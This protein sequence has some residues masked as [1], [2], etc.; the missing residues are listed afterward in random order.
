MEPTLRK[1][2]KACQQCAD[3]CYQCAMISKHN[4]EMK[5]CHIICKDCGEHCETLAA[6]FVLGLT[7]EK[8]FLN[9]CISLC[10]ACSDECRKCGNELFKKC[11]EV[12]KICSEA[13]KNLSSELIAENR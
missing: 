4:S 9:Y 6:K 8:S 7:P 11:S 13:L 3:A 12:A 1:Y 2:I 5:R 10:N